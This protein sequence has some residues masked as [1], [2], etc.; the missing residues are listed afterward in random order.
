MKKA[1]LKGIMKRA[2]EIKREH[3]DNIFYLCLKMAW[4]EAK[5]VKCEIKEWFCNKLAEK[6]ELPR[7]YHLDIF[8][9]IKA[10]EKA[11]YAMLFT[12][13]DVSGSYAHHRCAWIPKSCLEKLEALKFMGYEEA[14]TAFGFAF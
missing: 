3:K 13:Y 6:L 14:K 4:A 10:T 1:N 7:L 11:V 2:W 5:A 9:G 12:G 8:C